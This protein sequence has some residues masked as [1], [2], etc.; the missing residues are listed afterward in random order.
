MTHTSRLEAM[1]DLLLTEDSL[2]TPGLHS[3]LF[4]VFE[5]ERWEA[6]PRVETSIE[7][8]HDLILEFPDIEEWRGTSRISAASIVDQT[9]AQMKMANVRH[10]Y[11]AGYLS[12][13][14]DRP[15]RSFFTP[16][17]DH[18]DDLTPDVIQEKNG[19]IMVHEFATTK[20]PDLE[21]TKEIFRQKHL[22]YDAALSARAEREGKS[23]IFTVTVV[24]PRQ[25]VSSLPLTEDD[26][27]E[28][29]LR[30]LIGLQVEFALVS[31]GVIT[32][33]A[34]K[35]ENDRIQAARVAF[36]QI[37]HD[38]DRLDKEFPSCSRKVYE[39]SSEKPNMKYI[40]EQL[41][42]ASLK[43][44]Q[45]LRK[46][47]FLGEGHPNSVNAR[48]NL[49]Q[50]EC[51]QDIR[52]YL[53]LN[54]PPDPQLLNNSKS[55]IPIPWWV[56]KR[57]SGSNSLPI[58]T[59]EN[60]SG[61]PDIGD[62]NEDTFQCWRSAWEYARENPEFM[63]EE[64]MDAELT[65]AM[66]STNSE[67]I[68]L[69][70]DQK[71][72]AEAVRLKTAGALQPPKDGVKSKY[73]RVQYKVT[74]AQAL[75]LAKRGVEGK[76]HKDVPEVKAHRLKSK[77]P[78]SYHTDTRDLDRLLGRS[79][80][81]FSETQDPSG[82]SYDEEN[83]PDLASQ[84]YKLHGQGVGDP[85]KKFLKDYLGC[86]LGKWSSFV[87]DLATEL[88][89]SLRQHCKPGQMLLK[90]L[91]H[92]DVY[93]LIKPT[94]SGASLYYSLL[95]LKSSL[96]SDP[97]SGGTAFKQDF[98]N[99]HARWT[100]FNSV[101][102]SKLIN[103][104]KCKSTLFTLLS[105]WM[106]FHGLR[107][108]EQ[109]LKEPSSEMLEVW[110]MMAVCL[111][112]TLEDKSKA[113]EIITVS[114]F[115]FMEGL[116]AQPA[117]PKPHKVLSKLPVAL[118]SR[119][120]VWLVMRVL[121]A[122][123]R[124][125]HRPFDLSSEDQR[126]KWS[127]MFNMFTTTD[128]QEP[129]Q[130]ISLFYIGYLKN[131]DESPQGN[132]SA[133]LYDKVMEYESRR[134]Q[135]D[136]NLGLGD[137]TLDSALF[138]EFSKS[139]LGYSIDLS[140]VRLKKMWGDNVEELIMNDILESLGGYT[141]EE[142][143]T[144]KASAT[145]NQ[146]MYKYDDKRSYHRQKVV[147]FTSKKSEK[148]THV[149]EMV[150]EC[151]E[152]LEKN[153]CLH[154]DLFK[155]PQHGGLREIYVLGPSE[156]VVQLCLELIARAICRRFPSETMM[157]PANKFKLPQQHNKNARKS[158]GSN[159]TTTSTSDDASKWNQGHYVSKFAMM[160]CRFTD[161]VLHPFIMRACALFTKKVIKIDDQLLKTFV[162]HDEA[163]F[164]S[165]HV[166]KMHAAFK[167]SLKDAEYIHV[168]PGMTYLR[169]STGMLQGILHY[170]SS[171]LHTVLQ[172]LMKETIEG[173]L[174]RHM[175]ILKTTN[176][177]P[178]VTVMQS[179]DDSCIMISFPINSEPVNVC[180][181]YILCWEAFEIKKQLGILLGIYPSEKCTTNT[182]W[183]TEFNSEFFFMSDLIRPLFRWVAAVNTLSEHET[184]A[185]RQEEMASNLSNIL[186]GGGT[187]S[188]AANCQ[189]AQ[190]MMHYQIL[191]SG[192]SQLFTRYISILGQDPSVGFFLL[193]NPFMAGLCGFKFNL[194]R[195]V[196]CTKLGDKYKR[197][198]LSQE[199]VSEDRQA[200]GLTAKTLITTKAGS[201]VDSTI[202]SMSTR[203][204]WQKLV[205]SM[206][207]PENWREQIK[208]HQEVLY[209]KAKTPHELKLKLAA[210]MH[211]AGVVSSLGHSGAV[212]RVLASAAYC[213]SHP[214]VQDRTDWYSS[215]NTKMRKMSLF[216]LACEG[217]CEVSK[218]DPI[219]EEQLL[220]LF[221]QKEDFENLERVGETYSSIAGSSVTRNRARITT[222]V[223]VT[224]TSSGS[225]FSLLDV[226]RFMWFGTS[227]THAS[228][229]HMMGLWETFKGRIPWLKDTPS[230]TL[231]ASPFSD[232]QSLHNFIAG[233]PVKGRV[234]TMSG[235]P[236]KRS[237]GVSNLYTMISENFAPQ[238]KLANSTDVES[239]GK[240]ESFTEL[241][242]IL[243]LISQGFFHESVKVDLTMRV[244][245]AKEP[246]EVDPS[247]SRTRRNCLAILQDFARHGDV[248][249]T[250][251]L[252]FSHKLG[253]LGGYSKRQIYV[254]PEDVGEGEES[255]Y[256]GKGTWRGFYDTTG[257][258][259]HIDR[260]R[261]ESS[262]H[263]TA[264]VI[265]SPHDLNNVLRFLKEWGKENDVS[266]DVHIHFSRPPPGQR[267]ARI[268]LFN[269]CMGDRGAPIVVNEHTTPNLLSEDYTKVELTVHKG[270][271]RLVGTPRYRGGSR[272]QVTLL[273]YTC[274]TSDIDISKRKVA[275]KM[276]LKSRLIN[277]F[278]R[279]WLDCEPLSERQYE[280]LVRRIKGERGVER[281][282]RPDWAGRT[283][284]YVVWPKL[285]A[286]IRELGE[287]QLRY[288]GVLKMGHTPAAVIR[289]AL[290]V[291]EE[292]DPSIFDEFFSEDVTKDLGIMLDVLEVTKEVREDGSVLPMEDMFWDI[293]EEDMEFGLNLI[294][295]LEFQEAKEEV[296]ISHPYMKTAVEK[297]VTLM[298]GSE[299][300]IRAILNKEIPAK[301]PDIVEDT[302]RL[303]FNWWGEEIT[304]TREP[305]GAEDEE[306]G[307]DIDEL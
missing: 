158:C 9:W 162:K 291:S 280:K 113:E 230:E 4:E 233:D 205:D 299:P 114:R 269:L 94:N 3:P 126:P 59:Q 8:V 64:S 195:A 156:R 298:G 176:L 198:L 193:D 279:T 23:V 89:I 282:P 100:E 275:T 170:A 152:E 134:P 49:N 106:E 138:H 265:S 292:F 11:T 16:L 47:H 260:R 263:I 268:H 171:L 35:E 61:I 127:G 295:Q 144:L 103:L 191:G 288:S 229:N 128:I 46:E 211:S 37:Q 79:Q 32:S 27:T 119:L 261:D 192:A 137:P 214:V 70:E 141:L 187:T 18:N 297:V 14:L 75:E 146:S 221:P 43:A 194:F 178:Y 304:R 216:A 81:V 202:V 255:G 55:V 174:K 189:L 121:E 33:P 222:R 206:E 167:G 153:G 57:G 290:D 266:N 29:C 258:E 217:A 177:K 252:I 185:G 307:D 31:Q 259:I 38:W 17:H 129:M 6:L 130:M 188:L 62:S 139:F 284:A 218:T 143:G 44:R 246:L 227:R 278:V 12:R 112:V 51:V 163:I 34:V 56:L 80:R 179:S 285:E 142:L 196:K 283:E 99:H 40:T 69:S 53:N 19:V 164:S 21:R 98:E 253:C 68:E 165:D 123:R 180:Q 147:E 236:V 264:V 101:S 122:M 41:K 66:R 293:T 120:Q 175:T 48:L 72:H 204:R 135:S 149:H 92:F 248:E 247:A 220:A 166:K 84:A 104:V 97:L 28:L 116:V 190:M 286:R 225:T 271:I 276:G 267:L 145:Y 239:K 71:K 157:T 306:S 224:G 270:C 85:W 242:H 289:E 90:K 172:E 262:S 154:I 151:L 30:L 235:V 256:F 82:P 131:K 168:K 111:M 24:G 74:K 213:L 184:L 109:D 10:D 212:V 60:P 2:L 197:V 136:E 237:Y 39:A 294:R 93:V 13:N 254:S 240:A 302:L 63:V 182:P 58:P 5:P 215:L 249:R 281:E 226:A 273:S 102:S 241:R 186:G 1:T 161:P 118:R 76:Q 36:S 257:L 183:V 54:E 207:F 210:F 73:R 150:K 303:I 86:H 88:A 238:F 107:F 96:C 300:T 208:D 251:E 78:M 274:R 50:Q 199:L 110:K 83:L 26:V 132:S 52:T 243:A 250:K 117:L 173:R 124:I 245:K 87:S 223:T 201:I 45:K 25:V 305:A 287:I 115:V 181:G 67:E 277:S 148:Y 77:K 301:M 20:I 91:R 209:E 200:A 140:K 105:Y 169:T 65:R 133:A 232:A 159:F 42:S 231:E 244:L 125:S 108:W 22:R 203:R 296:K 155:K 272:N 95:T 15:L 219:T 234:V 228:P 160:L 7:G